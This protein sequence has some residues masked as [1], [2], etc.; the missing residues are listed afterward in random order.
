MPGSLSRRSAPSK[1]T[2]TTGSVGGS[3]ARPPHR[4]YCLAPYGS[5]LAKA[6]LRRI[7]LHCFSILTDYKIPFLI[8][9]AVMGFCQHFRCFPAA[10]S[11]WRRFFRRGELP[12]RAL[13][14]AATTMFGSRKGKDG[15]NE[16]NP[17][18]RRAVEMKK[19]RFAFASRRWF[20]KKIHY[21]RGRRER[22]G[23]E[24]FLSASL[25]RRKDGV[26]WKEEKM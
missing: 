14:A 22:A 13:P 11:A 26:A 16:K 8:I 17:P 7:P 3:G 21:G 12:Q 19:R 9:K 20:I 23:N 18:R 2:P 1:P 15:A 5:S 24:I 6:R 4:F 10:F 25:P